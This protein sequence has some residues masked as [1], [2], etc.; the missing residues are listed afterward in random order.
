MQCSNLYVESAA[1]HK[2]VICLVEV[3]NGG[4][5]GSW[6][7]GKRM[8]IDIVEYPVDTMNDNECKNV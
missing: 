2:A 7:V 5:L 3:C 8:K 6:N 1:S 4:E